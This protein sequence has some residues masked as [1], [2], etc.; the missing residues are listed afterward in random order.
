MLLVACQLSHMRLLAMKTLLNVISASR[1][2]S[3][4]LLSQYSSHLVPLLCYEELNLFFWG[5]KLTAEWIVLVC[6]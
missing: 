6:T 4:R 2:V 5:K 3:I 1:A